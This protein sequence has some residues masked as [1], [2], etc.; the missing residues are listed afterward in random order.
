[1]ESKD[2]TLSSVTF[3]KS[4][5][6]LCL[7]SLLCSKEKTIAAVSWSSYGGSNETIQVPHRYP[8]DGNCSVNTD[9][10]Q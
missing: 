9:W 5:L 4:L 8:V 3:R 6:S 2:E 10:E 7:S 1:M